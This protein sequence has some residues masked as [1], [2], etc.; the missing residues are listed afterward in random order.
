VVGVVYVVVRRRKNGQ[1]SRA[2][3]T[4]RAETRP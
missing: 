1:A 2:A 3:E 4:A